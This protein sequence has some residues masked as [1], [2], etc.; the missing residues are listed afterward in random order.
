MAQPALT[1]RAAVKVG[2]WLT[3]KREFIGRGGETGE[4]VDV[5]HDGVALDF[6]SS[7]SDE[8]NEYIS[9]EHYAWAELEGVE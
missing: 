6:Y 5:F 7:H 2:D 8:Y 9:I 1:P 3:V 4:V